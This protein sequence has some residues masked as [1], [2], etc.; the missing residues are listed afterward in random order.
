MVVGKGLRLSLFS[1]NFSRMLQRKLAGLTTSPVDSDHRSRSVTVAGYWYPACRYDPPNSYYGYDG[2]I[3][4][5][6]NLLPDGLL[7]RASNRIAK[8][9]G[10]SGTCELPPHFNQRGYSFN[11]NFIN[12]A[13][14]YFGK[15]GPKIQPRLLVRSDL[16]RT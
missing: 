7:F 13:A 15:E 8:R 4:T 2:P 14:L 10:A 3:Y 12:V 1:G 9:S 16:L 6:G 11:R 5:Y